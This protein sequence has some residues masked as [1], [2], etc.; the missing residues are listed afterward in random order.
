MRGRVLRFEHSNSDGGTSLFR[1][2]SVEA[3]LERADMERLR[4]PLARPF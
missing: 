2:R 4:K 1:T 3:L